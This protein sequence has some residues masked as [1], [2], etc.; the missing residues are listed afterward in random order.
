MRRVRRNKAA[1][2]FFVGPTPSK[3]L[4][5]HVQQTQVPE[6]H[7]LAEAPPADLPPF[8]GVA[9]PPPRR[10]TAIPVASAPPSAAIPINEG[11]PL[12]EV[13]ASPLSEDHEDESSGEEGDA[14]VDHD[15]QRTCVYR[16]ENFFV[17]RSTARGDGSQPFNKIL[18]SL[19]ADAASLVR[20]VSPRNAASEEDIDSPRAGEKP[21]NYSPRRIWSET[22][23]TTP[24]SFVTPRLRDNVNRIPTVP[25]CFRRALPNS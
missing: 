9:L 21:D 24:R 3:Q 14:E 18:R 13:R 4:V 15:R 1:A 20:V 2:S 23:S 25:N 10:A 17:P 16:L 7:H 6:V 12:A 19:G 11:V 5:Q 22:A 8:V